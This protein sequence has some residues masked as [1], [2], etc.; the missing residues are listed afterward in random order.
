MVSLCSEDD[1]DTIIAAAARETDT[2]KSLQQWANHIQGH[3]NNTK[4]H[5]K[6]LLQVADLHALVG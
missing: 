4:L 5:K 1:L 2:T 6:A 3:M